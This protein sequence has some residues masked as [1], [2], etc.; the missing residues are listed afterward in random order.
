[1]TKRLLSIVVAAIMVLSLVPMTV[2]AGTDRAAEVKDG[3]TVTYTGENVTVTDPAVGDKFNWTLS[4]SDASGL[5]SGQWLID[6][7]ETYL[8]TDYITETW[9]GCIIGMI[10]AI[11]ENSG[12]P[13]TDTPDFDWT[14]ST[15]GN[16]Q[17]T[18]SHPEA[19]AG[20]WYTNIGM[21]LTTFD[22]EGL[23]MGG[24]MFRIRYKWT[25]VPTE[26]VVLPMNTIVINSTYFIHTTV[27]IDG[28][29]QETIG[30]AA[31]DPANITSTPG[32]VTVTITTT[33][34]PTDPPTPT[35]PPVT[36]DRIFQLVTNEADIT[37]SGDYVIYGVNG[38]YTG[39]M[40]GTISNGRMGATAVTV[41]DDK[42]INPDSSVIW[43]FEEAE[44]GSIA[45]CND[46]NSVYC[47]ISAD[48]TSGF[49]TQ[50][51]PENGYNITMGDNNVVYMKTSI[52]EGAE[53]NIC[54]YR[55]DF[56]PYAD[57]NYKPLYLYKYVTEPVVTDHS[58]TY[59]GDTVEVEDPAVGDTFYWTMSV[60]DNSGLYAGQWLVD[61]DETYFTCT[62]A[63]ASW[64][65][66]ITSQINET[67]DEG[68]AYSD[69][70][71]FS[72]TAVY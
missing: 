5:Y 63:N 23:Q 1:M 32:S 56:R 8:T 6:Y 55:T 21:H 71:F 48:T 22:Y 38:T 17:E 57:G 40:N 36:E 20:N 19:V 60:S 18:G 69:K 11:T 45:I 28:E 70:P 35:E 10:N 25:A 72:A 27:I 12:D 41:T 26:S 30:G 37:P 42:I 4:V 44:D 9:S 29:E 49:S 52:A 54:I 62:E 15:N 3:R 59:T 47:V 33:P 67:W 39:A 7:D 53:R 13:G 51:D 14:A 64:S 24:P 58:V 43:H 66:G 16:Y 68:E 34:E 46:A 65:G 31:F 50:E 2:L 61:Y